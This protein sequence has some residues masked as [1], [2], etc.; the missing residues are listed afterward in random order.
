MLTRE[1]IE[2]Y[3]KEDLPA[4]ALTLTKGDIAQLV[5]WLS[6]KADTL[7]YHCFLLL[8]AR[9]EQYE[10]VFPYWDTFVTKL[11]DPNSYQRNIG[12]RMIAE[13]VRWDKQGKFNEICD[14][15]LSFCDD[16]KPVT[17]RQCIQGLC[18][19]VP[20]NTHCH[21]RITDKLTSI[22]ISQRKES[23]Q[24]LVLLDIISV[25]L[26]INKANSQNDILNYIHH[27][28]SGG[29]LDKKSKLAIEAQL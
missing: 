18:S 28:L 6:E 26:L 14:L 3:P 2:S 15:Y 22:D 29:L 16:E 23:Q 27:A 19:I 25:L 11:S 5:P 1:K 13:N 10:D 24:K 7:R 17:V 4:L 12:L 8:L 9:S 20:F 21:A